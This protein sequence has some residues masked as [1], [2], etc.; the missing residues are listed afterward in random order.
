MYEE[1]RDTDSEGFLTDSD[2]NEGGAAARIRKK[3]PK[4]NKSVSPLDFGSTTGETEV[5][6]M[7]MADA[8]SHVVVGFEGDIE[9]PPP[10]TLS[11]LW[12]SRE[13]FLHIFVMEKIVGWKMRSVTK[14]E[15]LDE[16]AIKLLDPTEAIAL[17]Q[18]ALTK[19]EFWVDERCR[20]E[21]S[22]IN[23]SQCPVVLDMAAAKEEALSKKN[24]TPPRFKLAPREDDKRE[25]VLL[26]K[27]RGRSYYHCSWERAYDIQKFDSSNNTARN[28]IRRFYQSQE[29]AL[30]KDW[31]RVIEEERA[32]GAAIHSHGT[33][34]DTTEET[35]VE[36]YFPPQCLEVERILACD[37][38]EMNPQVLAK[39][40]ALNYRAELEAV[41]RR[42]EAEAIDQGEVTPKKVPKYIS[43]VEDLVD[44]EKD[45]PPWDPEDNVRYVVKWKSLPYTEMTWE[46]W[47][48]IK[49]DAVDEAEDFW[50]RQRPPEPEE[51][52]RL[53]SVPHPHIRDFRKIQTSKAFGNSMRERPMAKLDDGLDPPEDEE[54]KELNQGF[55][56]RSYQ[57]E[58]VNWLLFNWWNHRSCILADGTL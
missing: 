47:R 54:D 3:R 38:N 22:R 20:M 8:S 26:V 43:L 48:D 12:Y 35:N 57:L 27:W 56:L 58:G 30:G 29:I 37:E 1:L 49:H 14:L 45:D 6:D 53:S 34:T 16:N 46:Y 5:L 28:K 36:E 21:V 32:T 9:S 50:Y 40:R 17:S 11:A 23:P 19:R 33:T 2:N 41:R 13:S 52:Q 25:E 4:V 15:W 7:A 39:Q 24:G 44:I 18:R 42:E 55:K 10:G 31:K 51:L